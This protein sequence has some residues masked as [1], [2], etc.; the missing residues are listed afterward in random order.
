MT[1]T[2]SHTATSR[3]RKPWATWLGLSTALLLT[4]PALIAAVPTS[5]HPSLDLQKRAVQYVDASET[6]IELTFEANDSYYLQ[7]LKLNECVGGNNLQ[8]PITTNN[9]RTYSAIMA[10]DLE[11]ALNFYTDEA[12]QEYEFSVVSEI[13]QFSGAFASM[14]YVGQFTDVKPGVYDKQELSKTVVPD[15]QPQPETGSGTGTTNP[16]TIPAPDNSDSKTGYNTPGFAVGMGIVGFVAMAGIVGL[17][18]LVYR[19]N[20]GSQKRGGDGRAFMTLASGQDDYDDEAGLTGENGPHS[21]A[22][23]QSRVGASFEDERYPATYK[24]E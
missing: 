22:L 18:V 23:M 20:F 16:T 13:H 5:S 7:A 9:V 1:T 10:P 24:D 3:S 19:R 4:L 21:S 12:C 17:G 14:K 11:M 6:D 8:L 15:G 2:V